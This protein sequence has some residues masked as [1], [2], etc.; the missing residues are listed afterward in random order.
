[1]LERLVMSVLRHVFVNN[2]AY[3][4]QAVFTDIRPVRK[5]IAT[6]FFRPS[7]KKF[8]FSIKLQS[9]SQP[10]SSDL[11][12]LALIVSNLSVVDMYA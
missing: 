8:C 9:L 1:M 2:L 5:R 12:A 10:Q 11:V 6:G 3:H 7:Q 4:A